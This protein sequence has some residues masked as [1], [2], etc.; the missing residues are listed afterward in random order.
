MQN[1]FKLIGKFDMLSC[2]LKL[3]GTQ[4]SKVLDF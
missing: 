2:H 4:N 3:G 1:S